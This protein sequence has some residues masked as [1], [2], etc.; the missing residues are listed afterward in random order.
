MYLI[1]D[2]W[3]IILKYL[4]Y[5]IKVKSCHFFKEHLNKLD[6]RGISRNKSIPIEFFKEH[7]DKLDWYWISRNES[8]PIEF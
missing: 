1:Q 2:L 5:D 4:D 7:I 8:I 3:N 6:W